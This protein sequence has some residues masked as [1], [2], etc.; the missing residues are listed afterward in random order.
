MPRI[1]HAS[2]RHPSKR[3]SVSVNKGDAARGTTARGTTTDNLTKWR[4][5]G[6]VGSRT[7]QTPAQARQAEGREGGRVIRQGKGKRGKREG[8]GRREIR[9]GKGGGEGGK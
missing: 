3:A 4:R 7:P 8:E 1:P 5:G 9:G 6:D 2:P